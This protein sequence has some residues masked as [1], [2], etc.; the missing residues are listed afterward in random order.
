MR[1]EVALRCCACVNWFGNGLL[2]IDQR[3]DGRMKLLD[4]LTKRF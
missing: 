4:P 2:V 3:E 1:A